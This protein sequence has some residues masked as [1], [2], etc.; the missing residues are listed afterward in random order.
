MIVK[1]TRLPLKNHENRVKNTGEQ[2]LQL[3]TP[4]TYVTGWNSFR[5]NLGGVRKKLGIDRLYFALLQGKLRPKSYEKSGFHF[6]KETD[7]WYVKKPIEK[8]VDL[9]KNWKVI[10][11][12]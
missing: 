12:S 1:R 10:E 6:R 4:T 3:E 8:S 2:S 11:Q 9:L 5:K 7:S